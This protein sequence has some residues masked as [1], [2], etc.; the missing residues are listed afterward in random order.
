LT[1]K[2]TGTSEAAGDTDV[3]RATVQEVLRE[4]PVRRQSVIVLRYYMQMS[5]DQMA[6]VLDCRPET[7]RMRLSRAIQQMRRR[8]CVRNHG[9]TETAG[10]GVLSPKQKVNM[11]ADELMALRDAGAGEVIT[12]DSSLLG[13]GKYTIRFTL[14]DGQKVDLETYYPVGTRQDR[15]K[16]FA[17]TR[18]LKKQLRFAVDD[19]RG[20]LSGGDIWAILHYT[21]ADGRTVGIAEPVL[22]EALTPDGKHV[23][24]TLSE[25]P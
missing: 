1:A 13:T 2:G 9:S 15:E 7:A 24:P 11:R 12:E 18:E 8:L 16:I 19:P 23:L 10:Q 3:S 14:S 17:E 4:L 20:P 21:M 22:K 6:V 25:G 5:V